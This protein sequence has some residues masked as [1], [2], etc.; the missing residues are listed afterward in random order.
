[1]TTI[2]EAKN[3][4]DKIINKARVVLTFF[5]ERGYLQISSPALWKE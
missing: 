2:E 3:N 5:E 4:L 1:M